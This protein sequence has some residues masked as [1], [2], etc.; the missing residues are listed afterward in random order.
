MQNT[1]L[2]SAIF[3][4]KILAYLINKPIRKFS[5]TLTVQFGQDE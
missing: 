5:D 1:S 4:I 2:E 3:Q